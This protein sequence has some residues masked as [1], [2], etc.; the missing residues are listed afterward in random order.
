MASLENFVYYTVYLETDLPEVLYLCTGF[1]IYNASAEVHTYK[2]Y[3]TWLHSSKGVVQ[4][5]L[6]YSCPT[7]Y[8]RHTAIEHPHALQKQLSG[9]KYLIRSNAR[10]IKMTKTTTALCSLRPSSLKMQLRIRS[11]T[12]A[13]KY[14]IIHM[15]RALFLASLRRQQ[16]EVGY[17]VHKSFT[18]FDII[19]T[20]CRFNAAAQ[21]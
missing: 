7:K 3:P 21:L 1:K 8:A 15:L 6:H 12:T 4:T 2:F 16:F 17:V 19:P 9:H 5:R 20:A 11:T 13:D 14:R 18:I 10:K